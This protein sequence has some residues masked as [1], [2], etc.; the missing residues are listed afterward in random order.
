M[1]GLRL[2]CLTCPPAPPMPA[3][4][5]QRRRRRRSGRPPYGRSVADRRGLNRRDARRWRLRTGHHP[6]RQARRWRCIVLLPHHPYVY[7]RTARHRF[8]RPIGL[9]NF[10]ARRLRRASALRKMRARRDSRGCAVSSSSSSSYSSSSYSPSSTRVSSRRVRLLAK[11]RI[12]RIAPP[13]FSAM[14]THDQP[15]NS[16]KPAAQI[17]KQGDSAAAAV[18][19]GL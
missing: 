8:L 3:A 9:A 1:S 15:V 11:V 14:L 12:E 2:V 19:Q 7:R 18:Q 16:V 17:Q 13:S 4:Q 6:Q 10:S 5:R